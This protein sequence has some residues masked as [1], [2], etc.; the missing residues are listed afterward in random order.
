[1]NKE[2]LVF[3]DGEIKGIAY[4]GA[5]SAL[6]TTKLI[7]QI[8][9]VVGNSTGAIIFADFHKQVCRTVK[10]GNGK[11]WMYH[12]LETGELCSEIVRPW[13]EWKKTLAISGAN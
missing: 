2:N 1:M 7:D 12:S 4:A 10:R 8:E 11:D 6:E 5:I 13:R 3:E 9:A